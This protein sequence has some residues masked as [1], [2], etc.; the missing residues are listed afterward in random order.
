MKKIT[1]TLA[2][3]GALLCASVGLVAC[4]GGNSAVD[5][6]GNYEAS[7]AEATSAYLNELDEVTL[8]ETQSY[9]IKMSFD[10]DMSYAGETMKTSSKLNGNIGAKGDFYF[11]V[12][13]S[14]KMAGKTQ[15]SSEILAYDVA[16]STIYMKDAEGKYKIT[17]SSMEDAFNYAGVSEFDDLLSV[18]GIK[19]AIELYGESLDI[20]LAETDSYAK[21]KYE[22][23][24]DYAGYTYYVIFNKTGE[25]GET[26]E[27]AGVR[28]EFDI[29]ESEYSSMKGYV[30]I[31]TSTEAVKKLSDAEKAKYDS[32]SDF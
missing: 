20:S 10:M 1:K 21:I 15:K 27:L 17:V 2:L 16:D 23:T 29:T 8:T 19:D 26:L 14:A 28:V 13:A 25:E 22:T 3:T 9:K 11:N 5:I 6:K 18:Q 12:S 4:G 24:G 30:E 31:T 32:L 7:S